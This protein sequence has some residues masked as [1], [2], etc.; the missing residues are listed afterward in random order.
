MAGWG[1]QALSELLGQGLSARLLVLAPM[2]VW[3]MAGGVLM[4]KGGSPS[5]AGSQGG[6][7]G[8]TGRLLGWQ[9]P[10]VAPSLAPA[11]QHP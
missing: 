11:A 2:V 9:E 5:L 10:G 4:A 7:R 1:F 8:R 6:P 3:E